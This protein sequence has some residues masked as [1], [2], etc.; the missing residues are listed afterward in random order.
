MFYLGFWFFFFCLLNIKSDIEEHLL[1]AGISINVSEASLVSLFCILFLLVLKEL[2]S[3]TQFFVFLR[4]LIFLTGFAYFASHGGLGF[5]K[6][7][8][9]LLVG[10]TSDL[11]LSIKKSQHLKDMLGKCI[12]SQLELLCFL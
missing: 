12:C 4:W 2:K 7:T 11:S 9:L 3:I 6:G 5:S 10:K 8:Q 1:K